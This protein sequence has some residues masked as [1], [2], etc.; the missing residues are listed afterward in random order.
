MVPDESMVCYGLEYFCFEGDNLWS[1]SNET[2]TELGK[3]EIEKIG[4]AKADEILDSYVVRQAKAYPVYDQH[5]QTHVAIVK[6]GLQQFG[7]LI[8]TGRNGMHKYN[9][10]DHSMMTAML[11]VKNIIAGK[12]IY[13]LWNVN[14]DA[15][16]LEAGGRGDDGGRKIP[17]R[18]TGTVVNG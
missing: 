6:K 12:Q 1:S 3:H 13:D 18:L 14:Q 17:E 8:M 16:Y 2:L 7:G 10:Q 4:L 9:N 11:A 5:Y 15:E